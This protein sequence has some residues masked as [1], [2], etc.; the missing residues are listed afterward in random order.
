MP[1][2]SVDV[3]TR[4]RRLRDHLLDLL[5]TA[6]WPAWPGCDGMTVEEVLATYPAAAANGR[7]PD[8]NALLAEYADLE[9]ELRLFFGAA[10]SAEER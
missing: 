6:C 9:V 10:T 7:V 4:Q 3:E 2:V 5:R 1:G 8:L